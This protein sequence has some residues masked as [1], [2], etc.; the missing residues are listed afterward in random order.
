ML[1]DFVLA[2][3]MLWNDGRLLFGYRE[4]YIRLIKF[5]YFEHR[6]KV[7]GYPPAMVTKVPFFENPVAFSKGAALLID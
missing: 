3:V 4:M 2:M 6:I 7:E 5:T 1:R